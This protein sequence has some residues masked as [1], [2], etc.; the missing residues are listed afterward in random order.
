VPTGVESGI[1]NTGTGTCTLAGEYVPFS[2]A[3]VTALYPTRQAYVSKFDAAAARSVAQGFLEPYDAD[4]LKAQAAA[5][6]VPA[7]T[8]VP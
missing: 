7:T 3:Q 1:G 5:S 6:A 4:V 2:P 8:N